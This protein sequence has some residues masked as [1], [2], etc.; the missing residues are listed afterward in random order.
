MLSCGPAKLVNYLA[1]IVVGCFLIGCNEGGDGKKNIEAKPVVEKSP[2]EKFND[3][4]AVAQAP[5]IITANIPNRYSDTGNK[6]F[7]FHILGTKKL[8]NFTGSEWLLVFAKDSQIPQFDLVENVKSFPL[9]WNEIYPRGSFGAFVRP[10]YYR[11]LALFKDYYLNFLEI[12][13]K[14]LR[15]QAAVGEF[16]VQLLRAKKEY[17]NIL[18]EANGTYFYS[19]TENYFFVEESDY[20]VGAAEMKIRG[21]WGLSI[22]FSGT[23]SHRLDG[24]ILNADALNSMRVP[25][26]IDTAEFIIDTT[27]IKRGKK[28]FILKNSDRVDW[29]VDTSALGFVVVGLRITVGEG[30]EEKI[31]SFVF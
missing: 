7:E 30:P 24:Y 19:V 3:L 23:A 13:A 16:R 27:K 6:S 28:E 18:D 29:N 14:P 5:E 4:L 22:D 1:V 2:A 9:E 15:R 12:N 26:D 10:V 8:R 20:D 25:M 31:L 21:V 11:E 17:G